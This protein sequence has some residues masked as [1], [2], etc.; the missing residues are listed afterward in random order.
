VAELE[1]NVAAG[2]VVAAPLARRRRDAG[3]VRDHVAAA[4]A[5]HRQPDVADAASSPALPSVTLI[6]A[7]S[8]FLTTVESAY[9]F[10]ARSYEE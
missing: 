8:R 4:K 9:W 3:V 2:F 7:V 6:V 1:G 10:D 5:S